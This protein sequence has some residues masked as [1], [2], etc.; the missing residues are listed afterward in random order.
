[1]ASFDSNFSAILALTG[2]GAGT[3]TTVLGNGNETGD[4]AIIVSDPSI[5][6]DARIQ[7]EDSG[8]GN[9]GELIIRG[10]NSTAGDGGDVTI[11]AGTGT[12]N[13]GTIN[14][15]GE[16]N[17]TGNL[18]TEL[19]RFG[20]GSPEGAVTAPIGSIYKRIDGTQG[21][22]L[23]TKVAGVGNVGWIPIGPTIEEVQVGAGGAVFTTPRAFVTSAG[24]APRVYLNGVRQRAGVGN[25]YTVT[26]STQITFTNAPFVGDVVAI[27]YLP[28]D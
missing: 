15:V 2:S 12:G 19:I 13:D 23:Y 6:T 10:G 1:M 3:L 21:T 7:G 22:T 8:V 27:D 18:S 4:N 20:T 17:I 11:S 14:L 9:A 16:T 26:S 25:D 28:A 5:N 24:I